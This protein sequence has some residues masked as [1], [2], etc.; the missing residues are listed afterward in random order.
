MDT[1]SNRI[2]GLGEEGGEPGDDD[3]GKRP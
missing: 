3:L 2:V 1:G